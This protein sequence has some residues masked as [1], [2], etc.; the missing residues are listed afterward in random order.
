MKT[1]SQFYFSPEKAGGGGAASAASSDQQQQQEGNTETD[2]FKQIDLDNLD[3]KSKEAVETIQKNFATLQK[4]VEQNNN[5]VRQFQSDKDKAQ[6]ELNRVRSAVADPA[7]TVP[8]DPHKAF[9][10]QVE[11]LMVESGVTPEAAKAQAPIMAKLLEAQRTAIMQEVGRGL[12]PM[13]GSVFLQ[14]AENAFNV[15][16][17]QDRLGAF[18]IPEVAAAI[19]ASCQQIAAEGTQIT[20]DTVT[21][22]KAMHYLNHVEKNGG[23]FATL[24]NNPG[25]PVP[26]P[27]APVGV[28][29]GGFSYPGANFAPTTPSVPDPNAPRTVLDP[30]TKSALQSIFSQMKP[31]HQVK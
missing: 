6:A 20:A 21:N 31:G 24:Q 28:N 22:L 19:W 18:A 26:R 14:Q 16:R 23:T 7:T 1:K 13:V 5:L 12:Q 27:P 8:V 10:G 25:V 4:T 3:E 2:P 9:A 30:G 11:A 29:T 15:A 17:S